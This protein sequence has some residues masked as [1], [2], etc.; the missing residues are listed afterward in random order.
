MS[1]NR[2]D[3]AGLAGA[4]LDG[5]GVAGRVIECRR[6]KSRRKPRRRGLH[7]RRIGRLLAGDPASCQNGVISLRLII[8]DGWG[9][10]DDMGRM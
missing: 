8:S 3:L 1:P 2:K 10:I 4:L 6:E 5:A 7:G 9:W